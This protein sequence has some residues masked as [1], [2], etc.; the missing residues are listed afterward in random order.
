MV[1]HWSSDGEFFLPSRM[2]FYNILVNRVKSVK[3]HRHLSSLIVLL[4]RNERC[5]RVGSMSVF[6][7]PSKCEKRNG[8]HGV[9]W[10]IFKC[11]NDVMQKRNL[12][13]ALLL[14]NTF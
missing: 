7:D 1:I 11:W 3:I 2:L 12:C 5:A 6:V 9:L 13:E 10:K 4:P 8:T 14:L